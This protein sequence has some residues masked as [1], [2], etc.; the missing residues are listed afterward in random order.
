MARLKCEKNVFHYFTEDFVIMRRVKEFWNFNKH[1]FLRVL[2]YFAIFAITIIFYEFA[3]RVM[4]SGKVTAANISFLAFVPAQA[5]FF[6]ALTGFARKHTVINKVVFILLMLLLTVF[7]G[8]QMVYF[9]VFGS[10][11]SVSLLGMGGEAVGNFSWAITSILQN[12][13]KYIILFLLPIILAAVFSFVKKLN[14]LTREMPGEGYVWWIHM[15]CLVLAVGL[16]FA[17][18]GGLKAAGTERNSAYYVL[19]DYYADSDTTASRIGVLSTSVIEAASRY[20]KI[21]G[22]ENTANVAIVDN[23]ALTLNKDNSQSGDDNQSSVGTQTAGDDAEETVTFVPEPQINEAIDFAELAELATDS[24]T[25]ML[26][27]YYGSKSGTKTNE[28]TGMFEGY[29]LIYI[30]AESFSRYA[31]DPDVTPLLY[32]MANN[33]IVLNNYYNSFKNTTSNGE[34]AFTTSLWPDVSRI[35]DDGAIIGSFPQS[36]NTYMP[37]GLGDFFNSIEVPTYGFHNYWGNYY[38]RD[39]TWPNLGYQNIKFLGQGMHFTSYWP[40]SDLEMFEQSVDD[41]IEDEQFHAYYMTFS[42]HGPYTAQNYMYNK[43]IAKVKELSDGKYDNSEVLGYLCGEYELELGLEY[44]VD[45]LDEA[46]KLDK[47]VIVLTGDHFPYYLTN[48][49]QT[50]F[51]GEIT[52]DYTDFEMY[53][54]TCII[55]NSGLEEPIINDNYC[56]NVDI[57]PTILNLFG[58]DYESRLLAGNDVFDNCAHRARLY[59][60]SFITEYVK[61]N[62]RT[63]EATWFPA[64]AEFSEAELNAYL[65]AMISYTESEYS[66]SLK[67]QSSN[68]YF[69]VYRNSGLMT[70]EE[71]SAE[72]QREA[73]GNA[74]Y[75]AEI[76]AQEQQRLEE[77]MNA[78][79]LNPDGTPIEP[80]EGAEGAEGAADEG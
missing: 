16:W 66:A 13:W 62:S 30:C 80:V 11:L 10:V 5:L 61:Y 72:Q 41:Y 76:Y 71:I 28:Y 59:N 32:E 35:A 31:L 36:A 8:V 79:G 21:K 60:G 63:G 20:L 52:E 25:K 65:E 3:L 57:L 43:N 56:C 37:Y 38:K 23:S 22:K 1:D 33:G 44:L 17:G 29:N 24:D 9:Q 15:V 49:G 46:G 14:K 7:Y 51:E 68:F 42:G 69:F 50:A 67:L 40:A 55:Y 4:I 45:R 73:R 27:E 26:C 75:D 74:N 12:V 47:T 6:A 19:N 39:H 18:I 58:F 34:F 54:S 53:R 2:L 64:A 70:D 78:M 48:S 77:E